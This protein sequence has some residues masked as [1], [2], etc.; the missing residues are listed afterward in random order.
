MKYCDY[1][2]EAG[3]D[4]CDVNIVTTVVNFEV[5]NTTTE[6]DVPSTDEWMGILEIN[7]LKIE[8]FN[9]FYYLW[10]NNLHTFLI[11]HLFKNVNE[12]WNSYL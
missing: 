4:K 7:K 5:E 10:I 9:K 11:N 1:P 8:L 2:E 6:T 12:T 3:C